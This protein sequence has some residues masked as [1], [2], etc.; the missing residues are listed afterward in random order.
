MRHTNKYRTLHLKSKPKLF[1]SNTLH[2]NRGG[3]YTRLGTL[4]FSRSTTRGGTSAETS[5]PS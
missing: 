4:A 5:P 2:K 1:V 3:D